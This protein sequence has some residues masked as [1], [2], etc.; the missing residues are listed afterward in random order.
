MDQ[1]QDLIVYTDEDGNEG[2]L[3]VLDYFYYNGEEYAIITVADEEGEACEHEGCEC[4]ADDEDQEVFF[5]KVQPLED[6]Q[7][8][9]VPVDDE[10][11][12]QLLEV[13]AN[14]YDE[15]EDEGEG[16]E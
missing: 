4:C 12:E 3:Q 13:I 1:E 15:D 11:A 14:Q 8:E 9:L 16:E 2:T 6:D 7:V 10:L 5:M